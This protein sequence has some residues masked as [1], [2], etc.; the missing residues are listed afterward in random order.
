MMRH[1]ITEDERFALDTFGYRCGFDHYKDII[2]VWDEDH[3]KRILKFIDS[4]SEDVRMSIFAV[5][6]ESGTLSVILLHN[7]DLGILGYEVSM[8]GDM[9]TVQ[10]EDVSWYEQLKVNAPKDTRTYKQKLKDPRWQKVRLQILERDGW[11]C[12]ICGNNQQ[13][14]HVHHNK[15]L[16]KTDPWDHPSLLLATLCEDCHQATHGRKAAQ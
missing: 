16:K 4:L 15:Y 3:D 14:L 12:K 9:W 1:Y 10:Y 8:Y 6:E 2:V 11:A 5:K 7:A 13:T